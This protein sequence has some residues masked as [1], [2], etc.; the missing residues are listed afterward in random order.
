MTYEAAFHANTN[1]IDKLGTGNAHLAWTLALYLEEPD[2]ATLA[3]EALTDGP[4][5]KK[6]DFIH[7]DTDS[8]RLVFAQGYRSDTKKEAA[9]ANKAS[10]LNTA[11]AW[12]VSGDLK[13]IPDRLQPIIQS[14]RT[15]IENGDVETIELLYVHNLPE[16]V[17]VAR[18]L[19]TVQE[20]LQ[21]VLANRSG[22]TVIARELG[23]SKIESLFLS[24]DSHIDV[25]D[26]IICPSKVQF[27]ASGQKWQAY[28][29][30]VPGAWLHQLF[31]KHGEA[32]FS[33]N[34]RGFLGI[35]K[36][37]RINT[38]IRASAESKPRDF[39]VF[40]NGITLLTGGV[41]Q[42]KDTTRLT[43]V[44]IINGAQTT[45][46]IGSV[47]LSK[48][49][50]RDVHVL[51]RIIQC[52]DPETITEVVK[53]N[54]TQNEIL[55]WDQYSSDSEQSRIEKEF[56]TLGHKYSRKRGVKQR[57][58]QIS[59]EEVAQPVVAFSGRY[60]EANRGKNRIF[61]SKQ[62]YTSAFSGRKARHILFVYTLA[63]A[64]DERRIELKKKSNNGT[65]ISLEE[66]QLGLLRN[67]RFKYF[68]VAVIARTLEVILGQKINRETIG[69]TEDAASASKNSILELVATWSS[70]VECVLAFV[71]THL[72]G[73]DVVRL[74]DDDAEVDKI[75]KTIEGII[76]ATR[77]NLSL[78]KFPEMVAPT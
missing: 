67:L 58:D 19:Q 44:S 8:R 62:N 38:G 21:K 25:K 68:L 32:L 16:S 26:E 56:E 74:M 52:S 46:S 29:L 64:I 12:L 40:N 51:C 59:L 23:A 13:D 1:L 75:V 61:E 49:D 9:P 20:H 36:R 24:Q 37:R 10:D 18:E 30:S 6:I 3:S 55:T 47:D 78:G 63:R 34:Y 41:K 72:D 22:L 48:Y 35:S 42:E 2:V 54:N 27:S 31:L 65:I 17:N 39:W 76:Y 45:G 15:A 60:A 7:L 28:V 14:C 50:L 33:A 77:N 69:F 70:I 53:F 4:D 11:A 57:A 43:G 5:D 71:A 66:D 73:K